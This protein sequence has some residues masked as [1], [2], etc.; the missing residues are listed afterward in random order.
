MAINW[1]ARA[2]KFEDD[3]TH[4][5]VTCAHVAF[6]LEKEKTLHQ[7]TCRQNLELTARLD[8]AV[9]AIDSAAETCA[10]HGLS[11][12]ATTF[13]IIVGD[14]RPPRSDAGANEAERD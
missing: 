11:G 4:M 3:M 1:K 7:R 14:L 2:K 6:N 8:R 10:A 13:R 9:A 5:K 12:H